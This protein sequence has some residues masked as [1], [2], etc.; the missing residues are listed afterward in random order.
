MLPPETSSCELARYGEPLAVDLFAGLGGW[1][2]GFLSEGYDVV[3]FDI[4][5]HV[6]GDQK[7]PGQLVL[8]DVLTLDGAQFP[9]A[10]VIVASP[11]CQKYSY[12]AMP[13]TAAKREAEWQRWLRISPFSPGFHLNDLFNACFRIQREASEA[14]GR[15]I[16]LV[17]ENVKGAQPW[18][19]QAKANFGSYYLWGDVESVGG[20]IVAGPVRFGEVLRAR[21]GRKSTVGSWDLT[22]DNYTPDHSWQDGVKVD[23]WFA[24]HNRDSFLERAGVKQHGSGAEWFDEALDERRKAA[25]ATKNGGDWFGPGE[26]CSLQRCAS[27]GSN[28]RRAASAQIAK[29][30][31]PLAEWIA[32]CFKPERQGQNVT[33]L[34]PRFEQGEVVNIPKG[35]TGAA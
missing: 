4:E 32:R 33:S 8:Q 30:P 15:Y 26:N 1:A 20:A 35:L 21:K 10:A 28:S 16:P 5:R 19:G 9:D 6:Y 22:R 25:T 7:Y 31:F 3:G 29:I 27:S 24:H 18:V 14:A 12:M 13:W 17:V 23:D 34:P 11:P 2:E